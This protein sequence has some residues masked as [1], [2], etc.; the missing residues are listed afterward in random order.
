MPL[1]ALSGSVA[2]DAF[3]HASNQPGGIRD[4]DEIGEAGFDDG[5]HAV[6]VDARGGAASHRA[7]PWRDLFGIGRLAAI[8]RRAVGV[9]LHG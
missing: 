7:E 8:E 5:E 3:A 4:G 2:S 1:G 6:G 9:L